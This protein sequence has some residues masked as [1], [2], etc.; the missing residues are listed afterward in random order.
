VRA[1]KDRGGKTL[2][3]V[4]PEP[5]GPPLVEKR[6]RMRKYFVVARLQLLMITVSFLFVKYLYDPASWIGRHAIDGLALVLAADIATPLVCM[7]LLK[8]EGEIGIISKLSLGG[9]ITAL[10]FINIYLLFL[11]PEWY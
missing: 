9:F 5:A 1:A 7:V 8:D 4:I 10:S 6:A 2:W 3:S 11:C